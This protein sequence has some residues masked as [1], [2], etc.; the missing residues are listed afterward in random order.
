MD[1]SGE[2]RIPASIQAVWDALNDPEVLKASIP[3][4]ES[5]DKVSDTE[6]T[7]KVTMAV[8]PVKARFKGQVK[9]TDIDAPNGYTIT[10]KGSGG[11]AG[12]GEG[13]AKV[14][15]VEEDG[16]TVLSYTAHASVGGKLAQIGQRLI[17]ATAKK[18]ANEFFT[19][20]VSHLEETGIAAPAPEAA[21]PEA[22][23]SPTKFPQ[24]AA[25]G[26]VAVAVV[27]ALIWYISG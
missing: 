6:F 14:T 22:A 21:A 18:M 3:G 26:A 20:F 24:W 13:N 25:L 4:C 15:L 17:D 23:P 12:F 10:G 11:A 5:V 2:H 16:E 9:L 1:M 19:G 7:A 8:G 27:L